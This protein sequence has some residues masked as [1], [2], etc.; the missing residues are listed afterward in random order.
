MDKKCEV[1]HHYSQ[2]VI[3]YDNTME[4]EKKNKLNVRVITLGEVLWEGEAV[5]LSAENT[6]GPFDIL[7]QHA[8][9]IT[10]LK[11]SPIVIKTKDGEKSFSFSRSLLFAK[12]NEV[13]VYADI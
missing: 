7:P 3:I 2:H 10:I 6:T 9:F 4:E 11:G 12:E 1:A 13:K 5:S 8:N